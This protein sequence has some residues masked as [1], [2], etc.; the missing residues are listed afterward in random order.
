VKGFYVDLKRGA[1]FALLAGPFAT[2]AIARKYERAAVAKAHELDVW[3]QFDPFG[4]M[5]IDTQTD[6]LPLG[7]LNDKLEIAPGDLLEMEEA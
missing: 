2:E 3:T 4:V 6:K 1:R 5:S 7:R